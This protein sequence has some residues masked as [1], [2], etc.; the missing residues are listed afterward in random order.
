MNAYDSTLTSH[1]T[2]NFVRINVILVLV[3]DALIPGR[4][5]GFLYTKLVM[6][7]PTVQTAFDKK[8]VPRSV[9]LY[10]GFYNK[11]IKI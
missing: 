8:S 5:G 7:E 11:L 9:P 1:Q 2:C 10:N 4:E 3:I 6:I